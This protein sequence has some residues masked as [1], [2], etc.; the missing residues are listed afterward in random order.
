[1][2]MDNL[3]IS[4]TFTR[5]GVYKY[6]TVMIH[7]DAGI[8]A[9]LKSKKKDKLQQLINEIID[10][11]QC[12]GTLIVPTF[13]YSI[14]ENDIFDKQLTRSKVGLFSEKFML[15]PGVER[16]N[17]PMFSVGLVGKK[18]AEYVNSTN[19][20]CFGKNTV[21]DLL[22]E[23]NAK[24]ICLGCDFSRITFVHYVEQKKMV[25]Y[26]FIKILKGK[27]YDEGVIKNVEMSFYAR[28]LDQKSVCNLDY[29]KDVAL[30]RKILY[31]GAFG[32]FQILKI[33]AKNFYKLASNLI[34]TD[35]YALIE[36]N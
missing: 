14:T 26:R 6:D 1:M 3:D 28:K 4:K 25:P 10:Y 20:D 16:T 31:K 22:M 19:K 11:F 29:M 36:K 27:V 2:Q 7:A 18:I 24:I 33:T 35:P 12:C 21:F 5:A 30:K 15:T 23:H 17:H 8:A 34:D 32:R 13:T 9:Q